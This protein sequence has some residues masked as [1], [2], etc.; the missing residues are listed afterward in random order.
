VIPH[1]PTIFLLLALALLFLPGYGV[2]K[3]GDPG[4]EVYNV[5]HYGAV[6]N[7]V[8]A[9]GCDTE[10]VPMGCTTPGTGT[11]DAPS[12]DAA[13]VAA[14]AAGGG[15]VYLPPGTYRIGPQTGS[16][17]YT[18]GIN[19]TCSN[20]TLRGAGEGITTLLLA[21]DAG[22]YGIN[23]CSDPAASCAVS[24]QLIN[25]WIEDMTI[26]DDDPYRHLCAYAESWNAESLA[27]TFLFQEPLTITGGDTGNFFWLNAAN[28]VI[29]FDNV[30]GTPDGGDTV[31][32]SL[33]DATIDLTTQISDDGAEETHGPVFWNCDNCG[34]RNSR[35][36]YIGDEAITFTAAS[37]NVFVLN[38]TF[39]QVPGCPSGGAAVDVVGAS[40]VK[41]LGN[42]CTLGSSGGDNINKCFNTAGIAD[43]TDVI[44][45]NNTVIEDDVGSNDHT[46]AEAGITGRDGDNDLR[47][48]TIANNTVKVI[49]DQV[50]TCDG[51]SSY[52]DEDGDCGTDEITITAITKAN[53]GIVTTAETETLANG[54]TVRFYGVSGMTEINHTEHVIANLINDTSFEIGDTSSYGSAGTGG[55]AKRVDVEGHICQGM[56]RSCDGSQIGCQAIYFLDSNAGDLIDLKI[57]DNVLDPGNIYVDARASGSKVDITDNKITG[58][59]GW[60]IRGWAPNMTIQGNEIS[61][62]EDGYIFLLNGG[63]DTVADI[64]GNVGNQGGDA[65]KGSSGG[66][67]TISSASATYV[68]VKDNHITGVDVASRNMSGIDCNNETVD[69]IGNTFNETDFHGIEDCNFLL[70]DNTLTNIGAAGSNAQGIHLDT[71]TGATVMGNDIDTATDVC[72]S[73]DD[74]QYVTVIGNTV[75][76]CDAPEIHMVES[77]GTSDYNLCFG[78]TNLDSLG[79]GAEIECGDGSSAGDDVGCTTETHYTG[80]PTVYATAD[81]GA[82][83]TVTSV[84]HGVDNGDTV[85]IAGSTNYNGAHVASAVATDTFKIPVAFVVDDCPGNCGTWTVPSFTYC[86]GNIVTP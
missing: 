84:G 47:N 72:I 13:I 83:T 57:T 26:E 19:I 36:N 41:I 38:N 37:S 16:N 54:N 80:V 39:H 44:I 85:T 73:C 50:G 74:C 61:G 32:G 3:M 60:G 43:V 6:A 11:D 58:D 12:V 33:S 66:L 51:D 56:N 17:I 68:Q 7:G 21:S 30:G 14:C 31:T 64:S 18:S 71:V 77:A 49:I 63:G 52:C 27:G 25:V 8:A 53:P 40:N 45:A 82:A 1:R 10:D 59:H 46:E 86:G 48:V 28:N 62:H 24:S 67:I 65:A 75:A 35:F 69:V 70:T 78:N 15:D 79:G 23:V 20:I 81:G 34:V 2:K 55:N 4:V 9:L 5:T 42:T 76:N 29:I 22:L